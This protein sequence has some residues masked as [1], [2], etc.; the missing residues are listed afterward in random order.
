MI[1]TPISQPMPIITS[2][3][4]LAGRV[5]T[6]AIAVAA[7]ASAVIAAMAEKVIIQKKTVIA[8]AK[9]S[10]LFGKGQGSDPQGLTPLRDQNVGSRM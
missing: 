10:F 7:A 4:R 3:A 1:A 2:R 6:T 8:A 5:M 9:A